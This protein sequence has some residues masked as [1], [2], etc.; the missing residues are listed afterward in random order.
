MSRPGEFLYDT[1]FLYQNDNPFPGD[2]VGEKKRKLKNYIFEH[3]DKF[4]DVD[5]MKDNRYLVLYPDTEQLFGMPVRDTTASGNPIIGK[6]KSLMSSLKTAS[7]EI[8]QWA[9]IAAPVVSAT[10]SSGQDSEGSD[11]SAS[12]STAVK[13]LP[14]GN[15]VNANDSQINL[16]KFLESGTA[17]DM[18]S[19][20]PIT[21]DELRRITMNTARILLDPA[22]QRDESIIAFEREERRKLINAILEF[23]NVTVI[24]PHID[25]DLQSLT[26]EQLKTIRDKCEKLHSHFKISE[27]LNSSFNLSNVIYDTLFPDG[28]PIGGDKYIQFGGIGSELKNRLLDTTKPIGFSFSRVLQKHDINITDE[29]A[30][31]IAIGEVFASRAKVV[32]K[33][34]GKGI[35]S[36]S[37][38]ASFKRSKPKSSYKG[39]HRKTISDESSSSSSESESNSSDSESS[40]ESSDHSARRVRGGMPAL[41]SV[42]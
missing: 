12:S 2:V 30:I 38:T 19:E 42:D 13:P 20:K 17:Y 28:I 27:V 11:S 29:L 15:I 36:K 39:R 31:A 34:K 33:D 22:T 16:A 5:Y 18:Y 10:T 4:Q 25:D 21:F 9:S 8:K 23:K 14:A 37:S 35:S 40:S 6:L 3:I 1:R 32:T 24:A 7:S 41:K 26:I